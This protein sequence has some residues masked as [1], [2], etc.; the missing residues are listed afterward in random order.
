MIYGFY[1][2]SG[3]LRSVVRRDF[4]TLVVSSQASSSEWVK[5]L[6]FSFKFTFDVASY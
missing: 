5:F 1:G 3:L 6:F 4:V 2:G